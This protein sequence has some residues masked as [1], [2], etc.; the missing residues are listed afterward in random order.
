M[1]KE[2]TH[3]WRFRLQEPN[4]CIIFVSTS[5]PDRAIRDL[6]RV[7]YPLQSSNIYW[8]DRRW[9]TG[10]AH[11]ITHVRHTRLL[12]RTINVITTH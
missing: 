9:A 12:P 11:T 7:L 1:E 8:Y 3:I 5:L 4:Y 2:G 10:S 6:F